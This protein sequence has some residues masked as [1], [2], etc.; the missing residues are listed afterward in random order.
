MDADAGTYSAI[1]NFQKR[2][3]GGW[4]PVAK[5][6][7]GNLGASKTPAT[8]EFTINGE[9]ATVNAPANVEVNIW[10]PITINATQTTCETKYNIGAQESDQF[11]NRTFKYEWWKWFAGDAPNNINVQQLATTYSKPPDCLGSDL[12]RFGTPLFGGDLPSGVPRY[13]R[14]NLCTVEPSWV[15]ASALVRVKY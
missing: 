11:W 10:D 3:F 12:T 7:S 14:V 5:D 13:Y 9:H 1:V 4:V 2:T 15:C 8:P 6:Y